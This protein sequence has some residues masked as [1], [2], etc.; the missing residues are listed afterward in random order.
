MG[1]EITKSVLASGCLKLDGSADC[2]SLWQV[3]ERSKPFV[4]FGD[5]RNQQSC[6]RSALFSFAN[7]GEDGKEGSSSF[8]GLNVCFQAPT[9]AMR[10]NSE[11]TEIAVS[12][13]KQSVANAEMK[14]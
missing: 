10:A 6:S 11:G 7:Y 9:I 1:Y 4:A 3:S 8:L 5:F 12:V 2:V 13:E 14:R